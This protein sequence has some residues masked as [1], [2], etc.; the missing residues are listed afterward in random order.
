MEQGAL[1]LSIGLF[2]LSDFYA[3]TKEDIVLVK[4]VARHGGLCAIHM[5]G[6]INHL[7]EAVSE[8]IEIDR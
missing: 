4:V 6:E 1:G 3:Q 7:F 5:C 8:V 2:Y